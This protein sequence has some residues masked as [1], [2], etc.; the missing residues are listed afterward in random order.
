[1]DAKRL[2]VKMFGK[3]SVKYGDEVLTFGGRG[4]SKFG[5]LFQIL[6]TRPGYGFSKRNIAEALYDWDKVE[7]PNASLNNTIFRL[8]KYLEM[9]PLPSGEYLFLNAGELRFAGEVEVESDVWSFEATAQ[10]FK[11]E[12]DRRKKAEL[13]EKN[14]ELYQGEFLPHLSNEQ[15]VID[16]SKN[17]QKIY[18]EMM[19]YL[20]CFLK[21]GRDYRKLERLSERTVELYPYEGWEIW[22]LESLIAQNRHN[23]ARELYQKIAVHGQKIGFFLSKERVGQLREIESRIYPAAGT[24]EEIKKCLSENTAGQGAYNC[25]LQSFLDCFRMMKRNIKR[26]TV[27]FCLLLCTILGANGHPVNNHKYCEKQEKKLRDVFRTHLRLGDI[28]AKYCQGQYLLLCMGIEKE[29]A[30]EIGVRI[31]MDFRRRCG[32]RGGISCRILDDGKFDEK[33]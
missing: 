22:Q 26:E 21:E 23:E 12:Q 20:F 31:D 4:D 16:K 17:Y 11:E 6:M 8:R 2:S 15:W 1:M 5:Q 30:S 18:F 24:E 14:S 32:G 19:E 9:S 10:E 33:P 13:C 25:T 7:Y 29:N 27:H 3:F 28:Y